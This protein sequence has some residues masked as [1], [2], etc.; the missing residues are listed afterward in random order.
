[1]IYFGKREV[2]LK[3][4]DTVRVYFLGDLHLGNSAVEKK[5]IRET[6]ATIRD[7]DRA[8]AILMGDLEECIA[9]DDK[10]FDP[11][12]LDEEVVPLKRLFEI[13]KLE[14]AFVAGLL[15]PIT[16]KIVGGV[17]GN[18]EEKIYLRHGGFHPTEELERMLGLP[19][20]ILTTQRAGWLDLVGNIRGTKILVPIAVHHGFGAGRTKGNTCNK[21]IAWA[22]DFPQS[23]I[24]ALGHMHDP[25][26]LSGPTYM[27]FRRGKLHEQNTMV[28]TAG[29]FMRSYPEHRSYMESFGYP[30]KALA[31]PYVEIEFFRRG[32]GRQPGFKMRGVLELEG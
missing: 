9:V 1:M 28:I 12:C 13:S 22:R 6:V 8:I 14:V 17:S 5:R 16:N 10:R 7:D 32:K 2:S 21:A 15:E 4:H 19:S 30:P 27:Q 11:D 24:V 25:N 31:C 18:H 29:S 26:L 3:N 23:R 20:G